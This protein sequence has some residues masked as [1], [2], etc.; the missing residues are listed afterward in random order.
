MY[1]TLTYKDGIPVPPKLP[2]VLPEL[3]LGSKHL[4][5]RMTI[6]PKSSPI[7]EQDDELPAPM[8]QKNYGYRHS[9]IGGS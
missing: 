4:I 6:M 5:P 8:S 2:F 9:A 3:F 1:K 7:L